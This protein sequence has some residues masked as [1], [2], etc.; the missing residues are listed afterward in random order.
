MKRSKTVQLLLIST[1]PFYL[2]ACN[3]NYDVQTITNTYDYPS[4]QACLDAKQDA[5]VCA[6][7]SLTT[8]QIEQQNPVRY[9]TLDSCLEDFPAQHCESD[10]KG[11]IAKAA[12][13]E[14][15]I[16]KQQWVDKAGQ[17]L[18][19]DPRTLGSWSHKDLAEPQYSVRPL[20]IPKAGRTPPSLVATTENLSEQQQ[21]AAASSAGSSGGHYVGGG[22]YGGVGRSFTGTQ[23]SFQPQ[24]KTNNAVR[25]Y[26]SS[27]SRGG[28]GGYSSRSSSSHSFFGG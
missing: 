19:K 15:I 11:A 14:L 22:Y 1:S 13:F 26:S 9:S 21:A 6:K 4:V 17:L 20:Y 3:Q 25:R 12:G 10:T 7:A 16:T 18:T 2:T 27:T 24:K 8:R 23:S 5:Q 28:F